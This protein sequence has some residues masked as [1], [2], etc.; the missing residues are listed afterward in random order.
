MLRPKLIVILVANLIG[1]G[2]RGT[3]IVYQQR[4]Q[5]IRRGLLQGADPD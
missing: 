4:R 2:Q 3:A 5:P 1:R